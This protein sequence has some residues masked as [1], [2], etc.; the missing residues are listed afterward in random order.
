MGCNIRSVFLHA[1]KFIDFEERIIDSNTLLSEKYRKAILDKYG[2]KY[3][4]ENG[5]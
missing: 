2:K 5:G 4:K 1:S 3:Q